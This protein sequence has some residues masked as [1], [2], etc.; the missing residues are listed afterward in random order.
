MNVGCL[1]HQAERPMSVRERREADIRRGELALALSACG[2][3][4]GSR[5]GQP[6]CGLLSRCRSP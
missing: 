5:M 2:A 3:G 1:I 6:G 4:T